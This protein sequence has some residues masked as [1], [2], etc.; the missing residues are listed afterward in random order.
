MQEQ[1]YAHHTKTPPLLFGVLLWIIGLTLIGSFV[2]LYQSIGD[3]SRLY[4]ASLICA[5][6]IAVLVLFYYSRAFPLRAQD[7]VIRAE[8]NLRH[9]VLA[10]QPP[11]PRLTMRQIIALRFAPDSEFVSLALRAANEGLPP[12][13][14]KRAIQNW[15]ADHN[16]L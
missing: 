7:R 10:G 6:S 4:N 5:I 2:N 9:F 16:R 14:I 1:S 11:D 3:H 15:R 13:A 12:D 8:E